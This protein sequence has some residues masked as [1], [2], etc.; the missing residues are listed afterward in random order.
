MFAGNTRAAAAH[1]KKKNPP[2]FAWLHFNKVFVLLDIKTTNDGLRWENKT[3]KNGFP[4]QF[5]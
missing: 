5:S 3:A 2:S 4:K 1:R